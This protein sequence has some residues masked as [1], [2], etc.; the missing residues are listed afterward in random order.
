[1]TTQG[2]LAQDPGIR[3]PLIGRAFQL[4]CIRVSSARG[5]STRGA[6]SAPP[7]AQ[8]LAECD[9]ALQAR[10]SVVGELVTR[11]IECSLR[12]EQGEEVAGTLL[13]TRPGALEG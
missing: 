6:G 8:R 10:Q 7:T 3:F 5:T 2:A 1:M 13:V 4:E 9:Q 11:G 12:L